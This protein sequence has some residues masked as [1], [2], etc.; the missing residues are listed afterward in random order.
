MKQRQIRRPD[1]P[2]AALDAPAPGAD[3]STDTGDIPAVSAATRP[4]VTPPLLHLAGAEEVVD[5]PVSKLRVS[6]C[7]ARKIRLPKRVSKIAES[8]KNN[9]QKDPLYVYPGAGE[10]EG[11]F[12]VLGGETRRLGALQIALP[13]LKAFVDRKVDP[14]DALNLTKISNILNDSADECDL[15]RGML[16]IDLLEKWH[17]QGE[18]AEVLELESHTHVQRLIKLAALPKRFIDFG[19]D[20]PERFSASLGAYISQ[21][22]DRHGED[23]AHNLLKAALVDELPHRKI[24]K[25]I[26]VGPSDK[27]PGQ[28]RGKRL[29]RDGGFDIPTP[30]APGGRY[31]VYKS[32]TPGL[33]V[34]KLQVEI[35]DELAKDLNEKLTEVLTQF[36]QT[37][38]EQ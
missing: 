1:M 16:A 6:P 33:K 11:Y 30:D 14:T 10:D 29:R 38:K 28:E 5:I 8:L 32:K 36:I 15:D 21:A 9:G 27:Q 18:V 2:L 20:Y 7:N 13:T 34:L 17:T 35:P 23:F 12:M 37:S 19:Q 24:A 25:A 4:P 3:I 26:E 31:D 22:I